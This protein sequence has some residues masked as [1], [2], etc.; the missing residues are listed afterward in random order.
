MT[1]TFWARIG[2]G[3]WVQIPNGKVAQFRRVVPEAEVRTR[4]AR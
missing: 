4:I 1:V 2:N 3:E